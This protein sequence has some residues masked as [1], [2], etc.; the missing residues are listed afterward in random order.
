MELARKKHSENWLLANEVADHFE[1]P[2][3]WYTSHDG[4]EAGIAAG[5]GYCQGAIYVAHSIVS[6]GPAKRL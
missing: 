5:G 3:S 2:A 4:K 1:S 6:E